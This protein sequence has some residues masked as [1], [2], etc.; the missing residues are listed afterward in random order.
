MNVTLLASGDVTDYDAERRTAI[1]GALA[2][3]AGLRSEA[4]QDAIAAGSVYI[5]AA[6]VRIDAS[7]PAA[8]AAESAALSASLT[9]ALS[10]AASATALLASANVTIVSTPEVLDTA[11]VSPPPP[12]KPPSRPPS[13]PLTLGASAGE[14]A[15]LTAGSGDSTGPMLALAIGATI[16]LIILWL[17]ATTLLCRRHLPCQQSAKVQPDDEPEVAKPATAPLSTDS[18]PADDSVEPTSALEPAA[19]IEWVR[20]TPHDL[21]SPEWASP[22]LSVGIS[23]VEAG[24]FLAQR[25]KVAADQQRAALF[26][27]RFYRGHMARRLRALKRQLQQHSEQAIASGSGLTS[28]Q[29]WAEVDIRKLTWVLQHPAPP[30][31]RTAPKLPHLPHRAAPILMPTRTIA[32]APALAAIRSSDADT[33]AAAPNVADAPRASSSPRF[34]TPPRSP[35]PLLSPQMPHSPEDVAFAA[36]NAAALAAADAAVYAAADASALAAANTAALASVLKI[37]QQ[38][39]KPP[40]QPRQ[41]LERVNTRTEAMMASVQSGLVGECRTMLVFGEESGELSGTIARQCGGTVLDLPS[42]LRVAE[43]DPSYEGDALLATLASGD[44]P[45]LKVVL[46]LLKHTMGKRSAPFVLN[47]YPRMG[48][49]VKDLEASVGTILLSVQAGAALGVDAGLS[50]WLAKAGKAVHHA[51]GCEAADVVGVLSAMSEAG[52]DFTAVELPAALASAEAASAPESEPVP[53]GAAE[54]EEPGQRLLLRVLESAPA[55]ERPKIV[56]GARLPKATAIARRWA[57][58]RD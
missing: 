20:Q 27:Q 55:P 26:V 28:D 51:S 6:S 41:P 58:P 56:A 34:V 33:K 31:R 44:L 11:S 13:S 57:D 49:Q 16:L 39:L 25:M 46:P 29:M 40:D 18:P 12:L 10:T 24:Q 17:F 2:S 42:L 3:A 54:P 30:P 37:E 1:L 5:S 47:G 8:S 32:P 19:P 53:E 14:P 15:A 9:T 45:S 36:A 23:K 38:Y 50:K 43:E 22:Y 21:V 35:R 48:K 4:R 52:I 7:L